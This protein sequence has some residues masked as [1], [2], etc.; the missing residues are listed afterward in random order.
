MKM[1]I[2]PEAAETI[3]EDTDNAEVEERMRRVASS[4]E[5]Y[6][7]EIDSQVFESMMAQLM[8][9]DALD[10][11]DEITEYETRYDAGRIRGVLE[12]LAWVQENT[13]SRPT[14]EEFEELLPEAFVG[15]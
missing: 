5:E 13:D 6:E 10:N 15:E 9:R 4:G 11:L 7:G 3:A 14:D 8:V 1:T 12:T 2:T